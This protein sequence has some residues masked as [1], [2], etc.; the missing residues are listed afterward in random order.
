MER[1]QKE[2]V[3]FSLPLPT[4]RRY[5]L[6]KSISIST[7][8]IYFTYQKKAFILL[9]FGDGGS[10]KVTFIFSGLHFLENVVVPTYPHARGEIGKYIYI[11][12][13]TMVLICL[14]VDV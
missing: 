7:R 3:G 2:A 1:T 13:K 8:N 6:L 4:L 5:L 14:F 9:V 10:V 12:G 11:Y